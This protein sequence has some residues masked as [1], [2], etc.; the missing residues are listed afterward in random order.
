MIFMEHSGNIPVFNVLGT[1]FGNIPR[2]FIGKFFR[3]FQ[4]YIMGMFQEFS[5]NIYLPGGKKFGPPYY[6][7]YLV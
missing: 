1:L 7:V 6:L 4:E 2:N 3:I 5:T